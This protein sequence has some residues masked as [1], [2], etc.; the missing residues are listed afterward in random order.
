MSRFSNSK[1][2]FLKPTLQKCNS[3]SKAHTIIH[4]PIEEIIKLAEEIKIEE[5]IKPVEIVSPVNIEQTVNVEIQN[6]I[7]SVEDIIKPVEEIKKDDMT[8]TFNEI[9]Y[10][11]EEKESFSE[12]NPTVIVKKTSKKDLFKLIVDQVILNKRKE[13]INGWVI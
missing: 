11:V 1:N 7:K 2:N 10:H 8:I 9:Y 4:K 13:N 6:E 12:S 3:I 5:V